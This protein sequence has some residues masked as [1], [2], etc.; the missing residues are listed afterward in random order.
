[1]SQSSSPISAVRKSGFRYWPYEPLSWK[2]TIARSNLPIDIQSLIA[3]VIQKSRLMRFEKIEVVVEL[4]A[5]FEDGMEAGLSHT[6]MISRF[7]DPAITATLIHNAKKRNR[8]IM[9]KIAQIF[10]WIIVASISSY[11]GLWAYY[12]SGVP[13]PKTDYLPQLNKIALSVDPTE[14]A[15]PIYR[16]TWSKFDFSE[17]AG[18]YRKISDEMFVGDKENRRL[19]Q[20]TD[21]KWSSAVDKLGEWEELLDCFRAA[22]EKTHLG[23]AL[24]TSPKNYSEEDR[25]AL[26]PG[27]KKLTREEYQAKMES[28]ETEGSIVMIL[29]PHIQSFRSAA[30]LLIVDNR[31]AV[32]QGDSARAIEN[33]NAIFGLARHAADSNFLVGSLVG[34]SIGRMGFDALEEILTNGS[35]LFDDAD[36]FEIQK[37]IER[38]DVDNWLHLDGERVM[39]HDLFQRIFTDDGNGNGRMTPEGMLILES[40]WGMKQELWS[41]HYPEFTTVLYVAQNLAQ[42][43]MALVSANRKQTTEIYDACMDLIEED[44]DKPFWESEVFE[45]DDFIE[46]NERKY[47]V[48]KL[49]LPSVSQIQNN[50][51]KLI[52]RKQA[53]LA[54]VTSHRFYGRNGYWPESVAQLS[55]EFVSDPPF[56][57]ITGATLRLK[58]GDGGPVFYSVGNDRDDDD[59]TPQ[60]VKYPNQQQPEIIDD[61]H[62]FLRRAGES[63]LY[64]GDWIL[65]PQNVVR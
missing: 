15:W 17:G 58:P 31:L 49:I 27:Y 41:K 3:L 19:V 35:E 57:P 22:A 24:Q 20:P 11:A 44:I 64:E 5:H 37:I 55:P 33:L 53:A 4:I 61:F 60:T 10:G 40:V 52:G 50:M 43:G 26:F 8:P 12:H 65:W 29:L 39:A 51:H 42:P 18:F 1:M 63:Q 32:Q 16:E 46:S 56:D 62:L 25:L 28:E 45:F 21:E 23:L 2:T 30:R 54:A 59:A 14:S 38:T 6:Q 47:H 13:S 34:F 9:F 48:L 36:L 7:G